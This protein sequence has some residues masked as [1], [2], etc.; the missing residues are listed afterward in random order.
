M[1]LSGHPTTQNVCHWKFLTYKYALNI[2]QVILIGT[3]LTY[4][5][6]ALGGGVGTNMCLSGAPNH[7][8]CLSLVVFDI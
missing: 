4:P 8:K 1:C 2:L 5:T 7:T 6:L 3:L